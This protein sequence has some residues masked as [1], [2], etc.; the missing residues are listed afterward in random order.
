MNMKRNKCVCGK[1]KDPNGNCDG[2]H[3]NTLRMINYLVFTIAFLFS[4]F[5]IAS[6]ISNDKEVNIKSSNVFWK[7]EKVTGSHE[8]NIS[9]K[10]GVLKFDDKKLIG[11][12]IV[13]NMNTIDCTDLSGEYKSKLEG[14]LK[15][16]DFFG[17]EKFPEAVLKIT[18]V[19]S[20]GKSKY[21]CTADL[22]IKGITKEIKFE[23]ELA[24]GNAT[25]NIVIDRTNFNIKYA[26][27]SF[28]KE[29]GDKMIYDEFEISVN[30]KY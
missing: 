4:S 24:K 15:S 7:G 2:S 13:I 22:T 19:R 28:F 10:S 25:T 21:A 1:T 12:N 20:K 3:A 6:S 17:V 16:N 26:S 18:K 23:A 14:H 11:G 29:L 5:S 30:L 9:L 8:G 27:G